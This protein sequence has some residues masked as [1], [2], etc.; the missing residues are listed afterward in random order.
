[1]EQ[2]KK[3]KNF[4]KTTIREFLNEQYEHKDDG[5]STFY[6]SWV[7]EKDYD[8]RKNVFVWDTKEYLTGFFGTV[9]LKNEKQIM[10]SLNRRD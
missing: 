3:L 8:K 6:S 10:N 1:M 9:G 7:N 4:I 2:D 5:S